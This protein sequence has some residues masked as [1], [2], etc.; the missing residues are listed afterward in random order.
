MYS[1]ES[2]WYSDSYEYTQDTFH[3]KIREF[4]RYIPKYVFL[5][6]QFEELRISNG[7]RAIDVR[8]I[9]ILLIIIGKHEDI[10]YIDL[11][12]GPSCSKLMLSLVNVS[13]KFD[14]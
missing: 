11:L 3:D 10:N 8:V 4:R 2:P 7:K 14:H 6:E 13:W 9:E 12:S 1:L 5:D